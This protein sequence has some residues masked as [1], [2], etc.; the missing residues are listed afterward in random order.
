MWYDTFGK[1]RYSPKRLGDHISPNWWVVA[2]LDDTV[3]KYY[4]KLFQYACWG[5]DKLVKPHWGSHITIVRNEEPPIDNR[6]L[7]EERAGEEI[8]VRIFLTPQTDGHTHWLPVYSEGGLNIR[9]E[10][11]LLRQPE[12]PFHLSFGRALDESRLSLLN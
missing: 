8:W 9:S 6:L 5:T 3:G 1:L 7:W 4:R 10:L 12:V 11:G 2:E